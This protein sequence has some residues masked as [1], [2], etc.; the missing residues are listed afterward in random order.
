MKRS[1]RER[2][3]GSGALFSPCRAYRYALWRDWDI[4]LP[5]VV[6]CGLNPSTADEYSDDPTIRREVG[7]ARAWGFGGLLKV[8]AYG[9]R[10]TDPKELRKVTDP[11]G[12]DNDLA[13][14]IYA[15]EAA[16]FVAAWGNNIDE[17]R[18]FELRRMLRLEGIKVYAVK[19]TN[20]GNPGHPLYVKADTWPF[21]LS[22]SV[23][24]GGL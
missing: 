15:H 2:A 4:S 5:R 13:I 24:W 11:V 16:L 9:L 19:V 1:L 12:E 7:F 22:S 8:N 10:S 23:R 18:A 17:R 3:E 14:K 20:R 21:E 6:F